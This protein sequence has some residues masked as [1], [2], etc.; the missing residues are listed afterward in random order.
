M[1]IRIIRWLLVVASLITY[2]K[3]LNAKRE[4]D[5]SFFS[6]LTRLCL[7]VLLAGKLVGALMTLPHLPL[8][9]LAQ[10]ALLLLLLV[11]TEL[12]FRRKRLTFGSPHLAHLS[13]LVVTV[14]LLL[15]PW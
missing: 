9:N 6:V 1:V 12:S 3:S 5:L 2:Y 14:L 15:I 13:Q 8:I 11:I 10:V 4:K 7:F